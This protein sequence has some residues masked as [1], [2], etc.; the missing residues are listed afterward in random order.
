MLTSRYQIW[1]LT[2]MR[3]VSGLCRLLASIR[4]FDV[5]YCN[6]VLLISDFTDIRGHKQNELS[7]L[8]FS[9]GLQT[10]ILRYDC[11]AGTFKVKIGVL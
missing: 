10:L 5:R 3:G 4:A 6:T 7:I 11:K 8:V 2:E 1:K 9:D